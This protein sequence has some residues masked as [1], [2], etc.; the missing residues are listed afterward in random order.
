MP[1]VVTLKDLIDG[2][3][4]NLA[5]F[6]VTGK[7][8]GAITANAE[9]LTLTVSQANEFIIQ[10][11]LIEIDDE[12]I[13]V[14]SRTAAVIT[15]V[16]GYQGSKAAAHADLAEVK[17]HPS[18]GWTDRTLRYNHI[19]RA[20]RWLGKHA[21]VLGVSEPFTWSSGTFDAQVPSS[22]LIDYPIGNEI[23]QLE[24]RDSS[25]NYLPFHGWQALG[26]Y[27]RFKRKAS[28]DHTLHALMYVYQPQ[29]Q[30]LLT[31]LNDDDFAEA[32]EMYASHLAINTLKTNRVRFAEYSASLNDRSSTPDEL[33]RM[34]FDLK[35]QAI[36][37]RDEATKPKYPT[38]LKTYRDPVG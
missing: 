18:W 4:E 24:Y 22:S 35:N 14:V 7:L 25:G 9:T 2:V 11:G 36:L 1:G 31:P 28:Q 13:Y 16:R 33:I 8:N 23:F 34:G 37:A 20:I 38:Y 3:R 5:S 21:W 27:I 6:P 19:Q 17:I 12:V 10:K 32:I 30:T 26:P 15:V 29:L